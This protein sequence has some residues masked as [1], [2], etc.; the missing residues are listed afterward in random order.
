MSVPKSIKLQVLLL[1][2]AYHGR[3]TQAGSMV[4]TNGI[5][6]STIDA[7]KRAVYMH[8]NSRKLFA[9]DWLK[10]RKENIMNNALLS[11]TDAVYAPDR[12]ML[13]GLRHLLDKDEIGLLFTTIARNYWGLL[14][15]KKHKLTAKFKRSKNNN[16]KEKINITTNSS[17]EYK[18]LLE[19]YW[20]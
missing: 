7:C 17:E 4:K 15:Y 14:S 19:K 6:A 20:R 12:K 2:A 18:R 8:L 3:A 16:T 5:D 9:K 11:I 1:I 10:E 13:L